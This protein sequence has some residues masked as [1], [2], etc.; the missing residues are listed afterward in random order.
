MGKIIISKKIANSKKFL[1]LVIAFWLISCSIFFSFS[2]DQGLAG[3]SEKIRVTFINPGFSD[4]NNPTGGFWV[5]VASFMKAAADSLNVDL[6]II[7]SERDHIK[8]KNLA[9][10]VVSRPNPPQYL[11]VVNEKLAAETMVMNA[12]SAGVKV[13]V[14]LNGFEGDQK[15][16]MGVPREKYK[17]YIGSLI[18]DNHYAGY[19]I[20]KQLI[21]HALKSGV[22]APDGKLHLLGFAGDFVTQASVDRNAG[23][24]KAVS[25]Y[26]NVDLKQIVVCHWSKDEAKNR[27]PLFLNRYPDI[28]AVWG[29]ND[30]IALGAIE[31]AVKTGKQPGKNIFFGGLNWDKEG[32]EKVKSGEMVTSLGGHFMTGGWALVLLHDYHNGRDFTDEGL[33]L[34]YKI[35]SAINRQN[36]DNFMTK[37][38]DRDWSKI[39][40]TKFSKITNKDL[41]KYNFG[42]ESLF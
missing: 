39:D 30:P 5:S 8:M 11:I 27:M 40:F 32:L 26:P 9:K 21:D 10:E 37:F 22:T 20:A 29:A 24:Q 33:E 28:G 17:N 15:V 6:E 35:F 36:I 25:E 42:I 14:I 16:K 41:I 13:I 18:P 3:E 7:Y 19:Q 34:K 4:P 38:G 1:A 23:L 31:G 2:A 12:D